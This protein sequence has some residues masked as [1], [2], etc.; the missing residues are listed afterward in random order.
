[1]ALIVTNASLYDVFETTRPLG[2]F[3]SDFFPELTPTYLRND[4][5]ENPVTDLCQWGEI[6][7]Y[8]KIILEQTE[9]STKDGKERAS[10]N[11]K[12]RASQ[13]FIWVCEIYVHL[14]VHRK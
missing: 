8:E 6:V 4:L 10:A 11:S 9:K 2:K 5:C 14:C 3:L 12:S 7:I 13:L 1:M